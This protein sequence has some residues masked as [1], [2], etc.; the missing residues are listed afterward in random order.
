MTVISGIGIAPAFCPV[1]A[2]FY[3]GMEV[4]VP[5]FR[6]DLTKDAGL[7][8]IRE[9]Y[10]DTYISGLVQVVESDDEQGFLSA[11]TYA[12]TDGMWV[13]VYGN[14]D[15]ML[16]TAR[17]DN[18]GKGASGAAVQCMNLVLGVDEKTG[19]VTERAD[20]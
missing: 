6:K 16:L 1:V 14:E 11:M 7:Q 19:L 15:R 10:R 12:G 3:S 13:S 9:L 8:T 2:D 17:Y 4:T 5:L 20:G 18:L